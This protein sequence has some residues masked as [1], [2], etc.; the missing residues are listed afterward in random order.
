MEL[1]N[2]L[3]TKSP[4]LQE[5]G[6]FVAENGAGGDKGIGPDPH[7]GIGSP[8]EL[9]V[10]TMLVFV[11]KIGFLL[12]FIKDR[13]KAYGAFFDVFGQFLNDEIIF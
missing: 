5:C 10:G 6:F 2:N 4:L 9:E 8:I 12:A 11:D 7:H 3:I 13:G 1:F